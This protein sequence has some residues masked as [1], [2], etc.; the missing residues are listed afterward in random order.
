LRPSIALATALVVVALPAPAT[1]EQPRPL[2]TQAGAPAGGAQSDYVPSLIECSFESVAANINLDCGN[3]VLPT[4]E[5]HV[6]VDP[7]DPRH[8]VVSAVDYA[9][10]A[11]EFSTTFDTRTWTTGV[12]SLEDADRAGS[13]PVTAFDPRTGGVLHASVNYAVS[14]EGTAGNGDVVVARSRDGGLTWRRPVVVGRRK[15]SDASK[16]EVFGD[17]EWLVVDTTP[18]SPYYGR[19]YVTWTSFRATRGRYVSSP[20]MEA[21]SG[22]GGRTWSKPKVIS[23]ASGAFCTFQTAG[24]AGACDEDQASVATVGPDGAVTVAFLNGQHEAAWEAGETGENQY[25]VVRSRDGGAHWSAPRHVVDLEDGSADLPLNADGEQTLTGIQARVWPGGNLTA[26]PRSGRLYLV[27]ADNRAGARDGGRPVTDTNV[28]LMTSSSGARWYGPSPVARARSDQF[29]PFAAVDPRTGNLGVA[30]LDRSLDGGGTYDA[31][32]AYGR[33]GSFEAR[34]VSTEHSP[35]TDA[36]F[37]RAD[38]AGCSGC[39]TFIGDY[40]GL[41]F[42]SDGVANLAWTDMRRTV[43]AGAVTA[44]GENSYFAR[45]RP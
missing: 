1:A 14:G 44:H 40:I 12:M 43:A 35:V 37:W 16:H 22:D 21:H 34:R 25:L 32:L 24:P 29:F 41:A 8:V 9:W 36:A 3:P 39:T 31:M 19:A 28:Y 13:H 10:N 26:D 5:Q 33:P 15:G 17:K 42:G 20:I 27:F 11:D 18:S 23:G 4:N 38:S 45:I 2:P 7:R 30:Y 6:A